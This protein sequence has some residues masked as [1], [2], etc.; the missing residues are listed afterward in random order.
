MESKD[1][2][3]LFEA[4]K[5]WCQSEEENLNQKELQDIIYRIRILVNIQKNSERNRPVKGKDVMQ[6]NN[7]QRECFYQLI[8]KLDGV[9]FENEIEARLFSNII[10]D[11]VWEAVEK[12]TFSCI[13]VSEY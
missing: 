11:Q 4:A 3:N 1:N 10:Y 7:P 2:E 5:V 12:K 8:T 13:Y 6:V 9:K